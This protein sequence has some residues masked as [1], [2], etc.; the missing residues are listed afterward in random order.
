MSASR[1]TRVRVSGSTRVVADRRPQWS[2]RVLA[3]LVALSL[4]F[5]SVGTAAAGTATGEP[6]SASTADAAS[7]AGGPGVLPKQRVADPSAASAP[8]QSSENENFVVPPSMR[9][10]YPLDTDDVG[11]PG[12]SPAEPP[13]AKV[14]VGPAKAVKGFDTKTS[15]ELPAL[16]SRFHQVFSNSDGTQ[17]T[18]FSQA[19]M[20]YRHADGTWAPIDTTLSRDPAG[21]GWAAAKTDVSVRIADRIDR[22]KPVATVDI[23]AGHAVSWSPVVATAGLDASARVSGSQATYAR[24]APD[25]DLV[26]AATPTGVKESIVLRSAAA[27]T[28]YLF[29]LQFKGLTATLREGR[30]DLTDDKGTVRGTIPAGSMIDSASAEPGTSTAVT[31]ALVTLPDGSPGLRVDADPTWVRAAGRVFPVTIDP[32]VNVVAANAAITVRES[33]VLSGNESFEVGCRPASG[34]GCGEKSAAYLAFSDVTSTLLHHRIYGAKLYLTNEDSGGCSARE[35]SVH[36]VKQTWSLTNAAHYPGPPVGPAFSKKAFAHGYIPTGQTH[37][38]CPAA[39]E[40]LDLFDTGRSII[41]KWVDQAAPNY[42]LSVRASNPTD[43]LAWKKFIGTGTASNPGANAPRLSITHSPYNATYKYQAQ[44][45]PTTETTSGRYTIKVTN[46]SAMDWPTGQYYLGYRVFDAAT[47]QVIDPMSIATQL[48]ATITRN[49]SQ[50]LTAVVQPLPVPSGVS[51]SYYVDFTMVHAATGKVFTDQGVAPLRLGLTVYNAAPTSK[52]WFPVNGYQ[53]PTLQPT[54]TVTASDLESPPSELTYKFEVCESVPGNERLGCFYSGTGTIGSYATAST[55]QPPVGKLSW[56][57]KYKWRVYVKDGGGVNEPT[58]P[59]LTLLTNVPQPV[60]T[61]KIA[62]APTATG[63][64]PFDPQVGNYTNAT[65]DA[66]VTVPGPTLDVLRTYNSLDPRRTGVFGAGWSSRYDMALKQ[67]LRPNGTPGNVLITYPDGQQVRFGLNPDGTW[68]APPNRKASLTKT[69]TAPVVWLLGTPGGI[70]YRFDVATGRLMSIEDPTTTAKPLAFAYG[71]D[72]RLAIV[73]SQQGGNKKLSFAWTTPTGA[74]AAH[75]ASVATDPVDGTALTWTYT[76]T[77]D[78]LTKVCDPRN[79]CVTYGSTSGSHYRSAVLDSRPESYWRLGDEQDDSVSSEIDINNRADDGTYQGPLTYRTPGAIAGSTDTAVMFGTAAASID[80]KPSTF[81]RVSDAAVEVWFRTNSQITRPLLGYQNKPIG[82]APTTGVPIL[83]IGTDHKLRGK[84]YNGSGAPTITPGVVN[85]NQWH[86]VVLSVDGTT[87]TLYLDGVKVSSVTGGALQQDALTESQWGA[88]YTPVPAN[89]PSYGT[90]A[91]TSFGGQLDEA[92]VYAHPLSSDEV[93]Q[94]YQLGRNAA[95]QLSSVTEP[96]GKTRAAIDYD[97]AQDRVAS[98]TDDNGGTWKLEAPT[99][100]ATDDDMRR[101]V[102][103][104]DPANRPWIYEYDA[105]AGWLLRQGRPHANGVR[106]E[107]QPGEQ[108]G[109]QPDGP[110]TAATSIDELLI[111]SFTHNV[112]GQLTKITDELGHDTSF[113]YDTRGNIA[114]RTVCRADVPGV[115]ACHTSYTTYK[116]T[117]LSDPFSPLWDLPLENRDARSTSAT[118]TTYL[119]T[120]SYTASGAPDTVTMP[121]GRTASYT[122][123][124]GAEAAPGGG[125]MPTGLLKTEKDPRGATT[126][127]TYDAAGMLVDVTAPSGAHTTAA[128]DTL[129]RRLTQTVKIAGRPDATTTYTYDKTSRVSSVTGPVTTDAITGAQHQSRVEMTYDVDGNIETVTGKDV[130]DASA[131]ARVVRHGY[132]DHN[133]L[134]QVTDPANG[135]TYYSFDKFG[136]RTS[137]VDAAGNQYEY[138][139]TASNLLAETRLHD[140]DKTGSSDYIV[141]ESRSYDAAG[142]Q[143]VQTDAL[144]R[145]TH[146]QYLEDGLLRRSYLQ[147]F[148]DPDGTIRDYV[149]SDNTYD[150]AGHLIKSVTDDGETTTTDTVDA[151]GRVAQSITSGGAGPGTLSRSTTY[152]YAPAN[153]DLSQVTSTGTP[154]GITVASQTAVTSYTYDANTGLVTEQRDRVTGAPDAVV[155]Q[156][157]RWTYD[158]AGQPLTQTQPRGNTT[159]TADLNYTTKYSYDLLGRLVKTELPPVATERDG[160]PATTSRPTL[161]AGYDGFGQLTSTK[162]PLGNV[163]RTSYDSRGLPV[164]QTGAIYHSPAWNQDLTPSVQYAYDALGQL[165]ETVEQGKSTRYAYDR[166]GNQTSINTPLGTNNDRAVTSYSY[167]RNGLVATATDPTGAKQQWTYDDLNRQVTSTEIERKPVLA[168]LTTTT[169]WDDSG[170]ITAVKSPTGAVTTSS[171]DTLGQPL[172]ITDPNNVTMSFG[173]DSAGRQVKASDGLGRTVRS[174]YDLAG[175]LVSSATQDNAGNTLGTARLGYDLDGNIATATTATQHTTTY[176]YDALGQLT[177]QVEPVS[178]TKTIATTYGYD[179]AGNNTRVTDG[180]GNATIYTFNSLGLPEKVI[181]PSTTANSALS[182]RTWTASY[183]AMSNPVVLNAPGGVHRD[184][185]FDASNRLVTETGWEAETDTAIRSITYDNRDQIAT[186]NTPTG[187]N[188]YTYNDRGQL[189]SATGPSGAATYTYDDDGNLT[190]RVDTAGTADFAYT[191][192]RLTTVTDPVTRTAETLGYNTAGQLASIN[193][194][195]G[196]NRTIGYDPYGRLASDTLKN[197]AGATVSSIAYDYNADDQLTHK[198]TTGVAGASDNTYG[199]DYLGR[200]TAWTTNGQSTQYGWDDNSNRTTVTTPS[201]SRT[202]TYDQRNRILT[203]TITGT[204]ARSDTYTYTPRG[205]VRTK[206]TG[207]TTQDFTFDAFDRLITAASTTSAYDAFDRP[208][209]TGSATFTYSGLDAAP[210]TDGSQTYGRNIDGSLLAV[211]AGATKRLVLS[212][213]HDDVTGGFDPADQTLTA[214][215]DSRTYNPFGQVTNT[216][217][218]AYRAGYQGDW[219]DTTTGQIN[220]AARWYN[221]DTATFDSRDSIT[222]PAGTDSTQT[223]PYAYGA[224]S[225]LNYTDPTGHSNQNDTGGSCPYGSQAVKRPGDDSR[226]Q[227]V[228]KPK[229]KNPPPPK[230]RTPGNDQHNGGATPG[231]GNSRNPGKG[232]GNDRG[233]DGNGRHG[234]GRPRTPDYGPPKPLVPAYGPPKP[235]VQPKPACDA[236]CQQEKKRK[237]DQEKTNR[238]H[239][240]IHDYLRTHDINAPGI[241]DPHC[242]G[243]NTACHPNPNGIPTAAST[244]RVNDKKATDDARQHA[245]DTNGPITIDASA[246]QNQ[247]WMCTGIGIG[248]DG[249]K[250]WGNQGLPCVP[251]VATSDAVK[252]ALIVLGT[253]WWIALRDEAVDNNSA[254][255]SAES[256]SSAVQPPDDDENYRRSGHD[257]ERGGVY[258]LRDPDTGQVVRTGRTKDLARRQ[259]EHNRDPRFT[260]YDFVIEA[261]TDDYA[262]Q[263]GLEKLLHDKYAPKHNYIGPIRVQPPNPNMDRYM[264]AAEKYLNGGG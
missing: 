248:M 219:T 36:E 2:S 212:D 77:G 246:A 197:T 51:K 223:N 168:N 189:L 237:Q 240:N 10:F 117:G 119:T 228:C 7:R 196:R 224:A 64:Q 247:C 242:S 181:D 111:R 229:P 116:T 69:T 104:S 33:Q 239:D 127:Y 205:T 124:T 187:T 123:T 5:G 203:D 199:Y 190:H 177:Q 160:Q 98:Y 220:M 99:T 88:A 259:K 6:A 16:R 216:T 118:D 68:V 57:K 27:A 15:R 90:T 178:A 163:D 134:S 257:D 8:A 130:L 20:N 173:Y 75:V 89:W 151:L 58:Q 21:S 4:A 93:N 53:T 26:L 14:G 61:S 261:R 253:G 17:T 87:Q 32:T 167:L 56:N 174:T 122:Y 34:G 44:L 146:Y 215:P 180:R 9:S 193:Y 194:G 182:D 52:R 164:S 166:L 222:W 184:R 148:H 29:R 143:E 245:T 170:N 91:R 208:T 1:R 141:L 231:K 154:S 39:T 165:I 102:I 188:T 172:T 138:A 131:P 79:S 238:A 232:K 114:S 175:Q 191:K 74:T 81:R 96:S 126:S 41:Q 211:G 47:K 83:Y 18:V 198:V 110:D 82:Q 85:D 60:L 258:T 129:G 106:P 140:P 250:P 109:D 233:D 234:G 155:D 30:V 158:Q 45:A 59:A 221:P 100:V 218:T 157:T 86:H 244:V 105:L 152:S 46:T 255:S 97:T 28:S 179:A 217:G 48:P 71:T 153:G 132:D 54:M 206:T 67:E 101:T 125:T 249:A 92:A 35:I 139:Y 120:T 162:D 112:D 107:D 147:G 65:L 135:E 169:T 113:T 230:T 207:G 214:L 23:D 264:D 73:T 37:S 251:P 161:L 225:P 76:Y 12:E 185:V 78:L 145:Q 50:V 227:Y 156:V 262:T 115:L 133:R 142:R 159:A 13:Q 94:H 200:M 256:S 11:E 241:N 213:N 204:G 80:L 176:D 25:A 243:N 42:G 171:Y 63:D 31:Y 19:P 195:Y 149:L 40:G 202:A 137:V 70:K 24:F 95:D 263:R 192:G 22:D 260:D 38:P 254:E 201:S 209:A 84:F 108:A 55:W 3:V 62:N 128:Y 121:D 103:V 252:T 150:A 72:G 66:Q 235:L 226:P 136:N 49:G 183:D 144:G 236:A 210:S 43:R 186:A